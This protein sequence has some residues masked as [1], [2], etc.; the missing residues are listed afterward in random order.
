MTI[1]RSPPASNDGRRA[2]LVRACGW[3]GSLMVVLGLVTSAA[4]TLWPPRELPQHVR[5]PILAIEL[6]RP[7]ARLDQFVR[8]DDS[9]A[10]TEMGLRL[11]NERDTLATAVR[12][13]FA[14]IAAYAAFLILFGAVARGRT[15]RALGAVVIAGTLTG[16]VFDAIENVRILQLLRDVS[17][18]LPRG[19]SLVKW[20]SLFLVT[21]AM[22]LLT[23]DRAAPVLRRWTG[24]LS[25]I[26]G[27]AAAVGGLYGLV[28]ANDKIIETAV[29][30]LA[31]AWFLAYVFV[32]TERTLRDGLHR[33]LDRLA[34][35]P[36]FK[37]IAAWPATAAGETVGDPIGEPRA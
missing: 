8:D 2:T 9:I 30:R 5:S 22:A 28:H 27:L 20:W 24:Y 17:A 6:L 14:F 3:A 31:V 35:W 36:V 10:V 13:D 1:R 15:K 23:F 34:E 4:G 7:G 32:A 26:V 33:A 11:H 25:A 12:L 21:A 18:P 29:G 37:H 16:A 19:P